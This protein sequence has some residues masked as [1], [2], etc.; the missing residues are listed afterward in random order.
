MSHRREGRGHKHL[1][2]PFTYTLDVV[3]VDYPRKEEEEA[4]SATLSERIENQTI[5]Q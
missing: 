1:R 3:L 2:I 4:L 5:I